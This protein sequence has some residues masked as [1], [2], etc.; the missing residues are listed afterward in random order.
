MFERF[1]RAVRKRPCETEEEGLPL[2]RPLCANGLSA[3]VLPCS[4]AA[5]AV[6]KR[7]AGEGGRRARIQRA[8][9]RGVSV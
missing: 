3:G 4:V 9:S 7:G 8:G 5:A 2:P 6:G 1:A